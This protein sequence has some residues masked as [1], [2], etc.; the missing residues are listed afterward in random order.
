MNDRTTK[1]G[2][3]ELLRVPLT[4]G[5]SSLIEIATGEVAEVVRLQGEQLDYENGKTEL[6]RVLL[7]ASMAGPTTCLLASSQ[8]QI[9]LHVVRH[10]AACYEV[11]FSV[12]VEV[13]GHGIFDGNA[14]VVDHVLA[15][16]P[17]RFIIA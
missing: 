13:S 2:K 15:P 16:F 5:G 11:W 9:Q 8:V 7:P 17:I 4:A 14:T 3:T 6:L 1:T 10:S 12:P